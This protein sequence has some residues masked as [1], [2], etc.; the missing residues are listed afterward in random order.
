MRFV[1]RHSRIE[2][3]QKRLIQVV[4]DRSSKSIPFFKS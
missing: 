3:T 1:S 4:F 2:E